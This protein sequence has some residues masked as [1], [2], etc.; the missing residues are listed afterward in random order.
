M[1]T[2]KKGKSFLDNRFKKRERF[3]LQDVGEPN[4]FRDVFP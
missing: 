4:L 1:V 3:Q 2:M